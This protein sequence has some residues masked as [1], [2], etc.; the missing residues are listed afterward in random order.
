[1]NDQD[2][3]CSRAKVPAGEEPRE[4]ADEPRPPPGPG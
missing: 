2:V 3:T 4:G 1:M